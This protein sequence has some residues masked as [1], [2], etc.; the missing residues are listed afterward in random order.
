MCPDS[1]KLIIR[2]ILEHP[3]FSHA[4]KTLT[5]NLL[6]ESESVLHAVDKKA[7]RTLHSPSDINN[8]DEILC[9]NSYIK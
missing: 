9:T 1:R 4:F 8:F 5:R 6:V 7:D 3:H 2:N